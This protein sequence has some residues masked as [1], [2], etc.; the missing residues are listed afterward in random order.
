MG[1]EDHEMTYEGNFPQSAH[2][3]DALHMRHIM[4]GHNTTVMG[5]IGQDEI[6]GGPTIEGGV[7]MAMMVP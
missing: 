6:Q 3:I 2:E 1:G 5:P 7:K 4:I